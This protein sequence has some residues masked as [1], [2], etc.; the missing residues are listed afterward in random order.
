[1]AAETFKELQGTKKYL[2]RVL[3]NYFAVLRGL[4]I[5]IRIASILLKRI[6]KN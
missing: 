2:S 6:M 3:Q 4:L 5:P 1:M